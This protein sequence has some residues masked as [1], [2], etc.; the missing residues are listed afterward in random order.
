MTGTDANTWMIL[1]T[2][3]DWEP[4]VLIGCLLLA[5][6]YLFL[7]RIRR[8]AH[9]L[10]FLGGI[11]V[12]LLALVSPLDPLSD[13]YL[14]SAH[15]V[16]HLL[17]ILIVP[18][19]L[20]WGIPRASMEAALSV[21]WVGRTEHNL[22]RP[23]LLWLL[24]TM[25]LLAW[26]LPWLYNAALA[27]ENV[28]IVMHLMFLV[29]WT[30]YWWL[31]LAPAPDRRLSPGVSLIYLF[32]AGLVNVVL[33]IVFTFLPPGAYPQYVHPEDS[34]GWLPVLRG[35]WGLT[36]AADQQWGGLLMWVP[37]GLV[38]L[39]AM[40]FSAARWHRDRTQPFGD[41]SRGAQ[42]GEWA[43]SV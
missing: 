6:A 4:S 15:M 37:A 41:D 40:L 30:M 24:A 2:G 21:G 13:E 17:L 12:M 9:L 29:T 16:Q 14:F 31:A 38:F 22:H 18:P 28:H 26:H 39:L 19:L 43:S 42:R 7:V 27:S 32:T 36:P 1:R 34:R 23:A 5:M 33:G 25:T 10:A 35:Q 11:V 3:W 8:L 20:L